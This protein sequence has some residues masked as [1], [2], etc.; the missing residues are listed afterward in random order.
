MRSSSSYFS[1]YVFSE[2]IT[3]DLASQAWGPGSLGVVAVRGIPGWEDCWGG[4]V[5]ME[6]ANAYDAC[7]CTYVSYTSTSTPVELCR[8][9]ILILG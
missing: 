4:R 1:C 5:V 9:N 6:T 2:D 8:S 3:C 7:D